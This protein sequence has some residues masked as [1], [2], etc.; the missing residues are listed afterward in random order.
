MN[1]YSS[2]LRK[3]VLPI[4][5]NRDKQGSSL[6]HWQALN[7]SQYWTRQQLLDYQWQRLM[8]LLNHVY[9][10][11]KYYRRIFDERGLTPQSF[12][13]FDDLTKLPILTRDLTFDHSEELLSSR[14]LPHEIQKFT[15]GG[16]TGQQA[17][18]Y[19]DQESFNIKQGL[20]WRHESWMGRLPCDKMAL[21]WPAA[22]D[23]HFH[24]TFKSFI[25]SRYLLRQIMYHAGTFTEKS[26][27]LVYNELMKFN[28]EFF[29]AFPSALYGFTSFCIEKNLPLPHLRGIMSTGEPMYPNQRL[30][31]EETYNCPAFDMYGS[32][33]VGNT[34][35]ECSL[36]QGRH[37]A[38]ETSIVEFIRDGK[39]VE[40]GA[41][42]EIFVTDLTN[43]AF[44]LI[45]YQIND[46]GIPLGTECACGRGLMLM[47]RAVGRVTD[48]VFAA[49]G[50]RVSGHA[51]GI[52]LTMDGPVIGQMQIVQRALG[53]YEVR[54]T[55]KPEPT[56]EIFE[57]LDCQMRILLGDN[58]K[59]NINIVEALH[60]EKSGKVRFVISEMDLQESINPFGKVDT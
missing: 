60:K 11:T 22:M 55:D 53:D 52:A 48:D 47:D 32:R 28:P 4:L 8:S 14:Y 18:L 33:E 38:M 50:D 29:K 31:F 43:L 41:E 59:V 30:L 37:I 44:P 35:C 10:T 5:L 27:S 51:L 24:G 6:R 54:I 20:T 45:R 49:N 57:F 34:A 2:I 3:T 16:T 58:I 15:S 39:P 23:Y 26:L 12:K 19:R 25:R 9:T 21:V 17:I 7:E 42:G 36:R 13:T 56:K 1:R 40:P 46:Y